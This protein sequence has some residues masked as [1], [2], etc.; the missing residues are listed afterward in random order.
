[1]GDGQ[2]YLEEGFGHPNPLPETVLRFHRAGVWEHLVEIELDYT[3]HP[4]RL[5]H[6]VPLQTSALRIRS[7][8]GAAGTAFHL[9]EINHCSVPSQAPVVVCQQPLTDMFEWL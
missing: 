2:F 5:G 1:M 3:F 6:V 7:G 4:N 8:G 9:R